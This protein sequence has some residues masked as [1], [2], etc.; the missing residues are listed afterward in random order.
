MQRINGKPYH[1][2]VSCLTAAPQTS[3]RPQGALPVCTTTL[4]INVQ[5]HMLPYEDPNSVLTLKLRRATQNPNS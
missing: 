3:T 5:A 1:T 4:A 2:C